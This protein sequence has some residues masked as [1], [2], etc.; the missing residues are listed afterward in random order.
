MENEMAIQIMQHQCDK[1]FKSNHLPCEQCEIQTALRAMRRE[2]PKKAW[3]DENYDFRCPD[4]NKWLRYGKYGERYCH[5]C[6]R[7]LVET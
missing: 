6:G 3:Q 7:K 4:C 2:V 1:C 5:W